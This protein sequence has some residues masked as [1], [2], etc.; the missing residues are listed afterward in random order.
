MKKVHKNQRRK[1]P[2]Y[3]WVVR[4]ICSV[5]NK[6]YAYTA[7]ANWK[8]VNCENCLKKQPKENKN[9]KI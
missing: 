1:S 2:W 8:D 7:S 3:G 9:G 6:T 4:P 5:D